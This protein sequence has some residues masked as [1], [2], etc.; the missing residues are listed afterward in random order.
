MQLNRQTDFAL[1]TLL[2]LAMA[3]GERLSNIDEIAEKFHIARNHLIKIVSKLAK[4]NYIKTLKGKG[5]GLRINP[6]T[7]MVPLNEIVGNFE[8]SFKVIDCEQVDCPV[9]GICRLSG[10]LDEASQSFVNTLKR[11]TL[12]DILPQS[13][14][15]RKEIGKRLNIPI[16]IEK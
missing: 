1:R 8:P 4:L 12:A 14:Y 7:L 2:F 15:E 9:T 3:G 16:V 10:I 11:Y 13:P 6:A 5:G